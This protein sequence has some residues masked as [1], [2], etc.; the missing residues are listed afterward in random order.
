MNNVL[1]I[2]FR[3]R[4]NF[5]SV[6]GLTLDG[7]RLEG[8]VLKRTNGALQQLQAFS[9]TLSLDPLTAAPELVGRE[10]RNHLDAAGVRERLCVVGVPLKW[11]FTAHTELPALPEADAAS[12]LQLEAER[13]F[14]CDIATLRLGASRCA[15][16]DGR[17]FATQAGISDGQLTALENVLAAA[18]L[19]PVSFALG[20]SALQPPAG[21]N[22]GTLALVV[23][24]TNVGMQLT[25]GGGVAALRALEDADAASCTR[26][27]SRERRA[28]RSASCPP[29]CARR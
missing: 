20:I 10:I 8:V 28:S 14:P 2:N 11:A 19:K 15:L 3:R 29:S 17:Q 23:G 22:P 25:A 5:T 21:K 26:T 24:E 1:K 27:W 16:T 18:K 12:L 6:L 4:K 13:G 9:A 7:S